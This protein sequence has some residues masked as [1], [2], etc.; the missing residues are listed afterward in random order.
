M[1]ARPGS[2]STMIVRNWVPRCSGNALSAAPHRSGR[3]QVVVGAIDGA[4]A[5]GKIV[6]RDQTARPVQRLTAGMRLRDLD[7]RQDEIQIRTDVSNHF[8]MP[9]PI[10]CD[11]VRQCRVSGPVLLNC[12]LHHRV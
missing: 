8:V 2:A 10:Y 9:S 12:M 11:G 6:G 4:Q 3:E 7:L 1:T 5:P